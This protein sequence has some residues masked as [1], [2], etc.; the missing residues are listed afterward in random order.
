MFV[1]NVNFLPLRYC[2]YNVKY[3]YVHAHNIGMCWKNRS[4]EFTQ[5]LFQGLLRFPSREL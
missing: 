2:I 1:V 5:V 4:G 3:L